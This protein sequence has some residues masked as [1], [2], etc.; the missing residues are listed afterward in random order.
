MK[1]WVVA[2]FCLLPSIAMAQVFDVPA[3]DKSMQYLGMIFGPVAGLP[4]T[5]KGSTFFNNL[6]FI[7]NQIVFFLG[8]V[9][10][11]YTTVV[12]VI[13]TAQEGKFLGE[14]WHAILVP[15]RAAVG[16]YLLL[17][18]ASGYNWIQ[19]G[20]LWF[21]VQGVGAAN[22]L[23]K[24]VIID[25]ERQGSVI[26][27]SAT[28][29]IQDAANTVNGLFKSEVCMEA[30]NRNAEAVSLLGE[31]IQVYRWGDQ[32]NFGR[33]SKQGGESPLCGSV[34]LPVIGQTSLIPIGGQ[35]NTTNIEMRKSIIAD[36]VFL[37]QASLQPSAIEALTV[38]NNNWRFADAFVSASSV[39][40]KSVQQLQFSLQDLT[41]QSRRAIVD[42]WI[43][44]GAYYFELV[45]K[46]KVMRT[47]VGI[48]V[49]GINDAELEKTLG[50]T[51]GR[52]IISEIN[53]ASSNYIRYAQNQVTETQPPGQGGSLEMQKFKSGKKQVD[54]V[55]DA[56]FD[57]VFSMIHKKAAKYLATQTE[58]TLS[59][60]TSAKGNPVA[61]MADFGKTLID[62]VELTFYTSLGLI[63]AT[64]LA[65]STAK[66]MQPMGPTVDAVLTIILPIAGL[67]MAILWGAG[68]LLGIYVPLI[69]FLVF[70][71]AALGWIILVIE[72]MLGA[73]LIALTLVIPS[74]D[75]IGKAGHALV[76]LLS[77]FLRPALMILGFII[78]IKLLSVVIDMVNFGFFE[79]LKV[80]TGGTFGS[81]IFALVAVIMLYSVICVSLVHEAFSLIYLMPNKILRWMGGSP[82]GEEAGGFAKEMRQTADQISGTTSAIMKGSTTFGAQAVGKRR[83]AQKGSGGA[84]S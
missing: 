53:T 6:L 14:K 55:F 83:A 26:Q 36:A 5:S 84:G 40:K 44:A 58:N 2:L 27:S 15:V 63:F 37:A 23:W 57:K 16:I 48:P 38:P 81:G 82:E 65:T 60:T 29:D 11:I 32:I 1:Y 10:I 12:G 61:A 74:E 73:P 66:C 3:S 19:V 33:L 21:I 72:A 18:S 20:V 68:V 39:L 42:G 45:N 4:I 51:L 41:K 80:S 17:P 24:Q 31:P 75:E 56:V 49:S 25:N 22:A 34:T 77:L 9:I 70:T 8:I 28:A 7:F 69:P 46:G 30:I 67:L 76:I 59:K 62:I 78:A 52:E 50:T 13:N 71:F 64:W 47:V 43:H 79:T 35:E 54:W